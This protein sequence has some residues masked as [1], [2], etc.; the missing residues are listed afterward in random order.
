VTTRGRFIT[1]EGG[2]GVGK[3]TQI[4]A[5]AT[6]LEE[7]NIP[8]VLT[9]EPGGTEGGEIIRNIVLEGATDRWDPMTELLLIYAARRDHVMRV[10]R[11]A[12]QKGQWVLCDRFAD[13]SIVYQGV[14][15]G[16]GSE[17]VRRLHRLSLGNFWPDLTI[18]LDMDAYEGLSRADRRDADASF[19]F[20][21]MGEEF[22]KKVRQA[23]L[24]L[25]D[26]DKSR[27]AVVNAAA[28][29]ED[30]SA[31]IFASVDARLLSKK[32]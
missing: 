14:V 15:R 17:T 18:L 27:F 10:V 11:P 19:R 8:T 2:E 32:S 26:D 16:L 21:R 12:L 1:F 31:N 20:E 25:A 13:S 4:R 29:E 22:H 23:F 9:R 3:T 28:S 7:K 6:Y 5:L 30:V 24:N